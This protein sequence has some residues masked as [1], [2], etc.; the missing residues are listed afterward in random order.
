MRRLGVLI[1]LLLFGLSGCKYVVGGVYFVEIEEKLTEF[2]NGSSQFEVVTDL[3]LNIEYDGNEESIN[4][5]VT[6]NFQKDPFYAQMTY[7]DVTTLEYEDNDLVTHVTFDHHN[8]VNGIQ[9]YEIS[10]YTNEPI[11]NPLDDLDFDLSKVEIM[12]ISGSHYRIKGNL[13]DFLPESTLEE[14]ETALVQSGLSKDD[15]EDTEIKMDFIFATGEFKYGLS[16]HFDIDDIV[17][18]ITFDFLFHYDTFV[19]IDIHDEDLFYP[20]TC[21]DET[22]LID[23]TKPILFT[24]NEYYISQYNVYLEAGTYGFITSQ[25][26]DENNPLYLSISSRENG[27]EDLKVFADVYSRYNNNPINIDRFYEIPTDGYYVIQAEYPLSDEPY[28]TQLEKLQ[29]ETDGI[30]QTDLVISESG[31]YAYEIEHMY[32]FIS[33]DFDIDSY[34]SVTLLDSQNNSVYLNNDNYGTYSSIELNQYT[35]QFLLNEDNHK[36]Y[37]HNP[38]GASEGV[39][40]IGM[41]PFKHAV[42]PSSETMLDMEPNFTT[43]Y[44]FSYYSYPDQYMALYV[45][46]FKAYTFEYLIIQ[47]NLTNASGSLYTENGGLVSRI[48]DGK[49]VILQPG[50]YYYRSNDDFEGS[51]SIRYVISDV[52]VTSHTITTLQSYD[53]LGGNLLE[54]PHFSGRIQYRDEYIIYLFSLDVETDIMFTNNEKFELYDSTQTCISLGIRDSGYMVYRLQPG[55]YYVRV[56]SPVTAEASNFPMDYIFHLCK[57]TGGGVDNSIYPYFDTIP[58]SH[59][60]VTSTFDY[61]N[62]TDGYTFTL[63]ETTDVH[64]YTNKTAML[65]KDGK[66]YRSS[67]NSD[68]YILP[69]GV[70][71]IL[72][73]YYTGNWSLVIYENE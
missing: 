34:T 1:I 31:Q 17:I 30:K 37:L 54:M 14:L 20:M 18:D 15:F 4:E 66:I 55:N 5:T 24:A 49:S 59:E 52:S 43:D 64:I 26:G 28:I 19:P 73:T 35:I 22:T 60:F 38:S 46:E 71:Q 16:L 32:D 36:I 45:P 57:F 47:G 42:E 9:L 3:S 12:K 56:I 29:Y 63:T 39:L 61:S 2:E 41:E 13:Y 6:A 53:T 23:A 62:D 27:A 58:F 51:Y 50:N 21:S 10:Q 67:L 7:S 25:E 70:Y 40:T 72:C 68:D 48:D 44:I 8:Q 69:A 11:S 33:I 65:A